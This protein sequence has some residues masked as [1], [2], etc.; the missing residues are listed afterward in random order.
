MA[1]KIGLASV[2][3]VGTH[4]CLT[5]F[6]AVT[7]ADNLDGGAITESLLSIMAAKGHEARYELPGG[8]PANPKRVLIFTAPN[9]RSP[10]SGGSAAPAGAQIRVMATSSS[11]LRRSRSSRGS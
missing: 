3:R 2:N 4:S 10:A 1:P 6:K 9:M 8:T 5:C 11:G 7:T